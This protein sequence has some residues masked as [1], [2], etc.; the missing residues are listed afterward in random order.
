MYLHLLYEI[1]D[2][3]PGSVQDGTD[4]SHKNPRPL[5]PRKFKKIPETHESPRQM[6]KG[7]EKTHV[8]QGF[9]REER[10]TMDG[11]IGNLEYMNGK[12]DDIETLHELSIVPVKDK[13]TDPQDK[14]RVYEP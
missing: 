1:S 7:G 10:D 2:T 13:E 3:S 11:F 6:C 9:S 5:R 14:L 4:V 12:D 8:S